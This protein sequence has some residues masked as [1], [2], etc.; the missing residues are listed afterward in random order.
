M[1]PGL[2]IDYTRSMKVNT[3]VEFLVQES[4]QLCSAVQEP[5]AAQ[6]L[7]TSCVSLW[8]P[9]LLT[10]YLTGSPVQAKLGNNALFEMEAP[11]LL[12]SFR[13]RVSLRVQL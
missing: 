12:F 1:F 2:A 4:F 7:T 10:D 6:Q 5:P 9:L 3:A 13:R 11:F 8:L